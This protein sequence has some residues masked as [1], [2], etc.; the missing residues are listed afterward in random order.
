MKWQV[1]KAA[2]LA[3]Y[4]NKPTIYDGGNESGTRNETHY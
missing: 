2:K 1:I 3:K 4:I